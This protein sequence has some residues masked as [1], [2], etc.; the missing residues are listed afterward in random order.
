VAVAV[1]Q[2]QQEIMVN[3]VMVME[4]LA[5]HHHFQEHQ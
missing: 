5:L 4:V 3:Q 2:V 1:E